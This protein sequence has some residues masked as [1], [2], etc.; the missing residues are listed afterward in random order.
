MAIDVGILFVMTTIVSWGTADFFAK[1]AIDKTGY[2]LSLVI[3]QLVALGPIFIYAFLFSKIPPLT[4]SLV[5]TAIACGV[6]GIIGY[7]YM[8]KGFQKGNISVVS[9]ISSSW[10]LITTLVALLI[11]KETLMPL[12]IA[13]V[14]VVFVG[15]FLASTKLQELKQSIKQGRSNGVLEGLITMITWGIAFALIKPLAFFAGP[16]VALL[17]MRS[18]MFLSLFSWAAIKKSRISFPT[19]AI[20]LFLAIAGLLDA[21]GFAAFNIS[22]TTEFVSLVSPA[23]ATYPAVTVIL[24]YFF[25]K[26]RVSFNQKIGIV[27]I[28]AGLVLVALI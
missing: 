14:V 9:P 28:L 13:G 17:F 27:A 19:K 7:F 26:E 8:Y 16:I 6:L 4:T 22:V 5:L 23:V 20:F 18:V 3:S 2:L 10:A 1:K 21:V 24:A 12:Q 11:F 25:L 15:I